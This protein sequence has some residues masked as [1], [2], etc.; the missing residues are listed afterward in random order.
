MKSVGVCYWH[1]P[2][3]PGRSDDVRL[4]GKTGSERWAVKVT[5]LTQLRH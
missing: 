3:L 2:D 5:R 4:S 1:Q